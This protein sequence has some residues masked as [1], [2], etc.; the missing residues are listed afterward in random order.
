[1]ALGSSAQQ[2][3]RVL[4][5]S[6]DPLT[7]RKVARLADIS[8]T[9]ASRVLNELMEL[10]AVE[11]KISGRSYLWTSSVQ[12][13]QFLVGATDGE[14]GHRVAVI[15]TA[16]PLEFNAVRQGLLNGSMERAALGLRFLRGTVT[17]EAIDWT[18]YLAQAGMGNASTASVVAHAVSELRADLVAFVG[19]AAGL[20]PDDQAVGDV[21][22]ASRVYNG[23]SGKEAVIDGQA[24]FLG[25]PA[26]FS[27][28]MSLQAGTS[29]H[30]GLRLGWAGSSARKRAIVSRSFSACGTD[31]Q[32]GVG[33]GKPPRR[34]ARPNRNA[35]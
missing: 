8:T 21:L 15:M 2:V 7:T 26:S 24:E 5:A 33:T 17:G 11:V 3:L 12:A 19:T 31:S 16:V 20:K 23:H 29:A 6:S 1:M 9:T 28:P 34:A 35:L 14:R 4:R 27:T 13:G 25:R 10:G 22:F 30:R 32:C 18:V